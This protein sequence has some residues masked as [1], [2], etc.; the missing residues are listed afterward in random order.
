MRAVSRTLPHLRRYRI[1]KPISP[2]LTEWLVLE[3][4]P[5]GIG[6]EYPRAVCSSPDEA[7]RALRTLLDR[8][9]EEM[10]AYAQLATRATAA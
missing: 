9:R 5:Y 3:E 8:D 4:N 2:T 1:R 6:G 10:K 7:G